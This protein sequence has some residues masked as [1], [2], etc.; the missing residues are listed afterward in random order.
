MTA[1]QRSED[2][3]LADMAVL[4]AAL[5]SLPPLIRY[6][7]DFLDKMHTVHDWPECHSFSLQSDGAKQTIRLDTLAP[8]TQVMKWVVTDWFQHVDPTTVTGYFQGVVL[9]VSEIGLSTFLGLILATP[10]DARATW[11]TVVIAKIT[12]SNSA[13][14]LKSLLHSLCR[15]RVGHWA[16]SSATLIRG[17]K[18]PKLDKYRTVRTGDCFVPLDQQA[19]IINYIDEACGNVASLDND[20]LRDVCMLVISF[21]YAFRRGQIARI[22]LADVRSYSTGAVHIAFLLTKKKDKRKRIRVTRRINRE[23]APLFVEMLKRRDSGMITAKKGVPHHLF[24]GLTPGDVGLSIQQLT[25]EV[26]SDAWTV[27]DLRHTAGQ[28]MADGGTSH[29]GLTEFMGHT[30]ERTANV[31]F[32]K[33]QSQAKRINDSLGLSPTYVAL[34]DIGRTKTIDMRKLLDLPTE[35]QIGGVP[36]GVPIA[37]IGGC[38]L[39]QNLCMKNPVI[40]CYTCSRFMP[41]NDPNIHQ[42][43]LDGLRPVVT[44]FAAA[45]R[46]NQQSPAFAQL[47]GTIDAVQRLVVELQPGAL[48]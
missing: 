43:V 5:P 10:F 38:S 37:G 30:S 33:S 39:G 45:S 47:K 4:S 35:Q 17:L 25:E 8:A 28:R 11:N 34:A 32:D 13:A 12:S 24:F 1:L 23:W 14:A 27:T 46:G 31:Y 21:Q 19:R 3:L 7:D 48:K 16:E 20:V 6:Y 42:E 41:L 22:A 36:H 44:E 2:Q 9:A 26:T 15:L 40:A 18:T 29:S